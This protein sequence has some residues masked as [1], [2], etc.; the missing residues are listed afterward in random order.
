MVAVALPTFIDA[1][2][3]TL[4]GDRLFRMW[5][6]FLAYSVIASGQGSA[7]CWQILAHP[8][9]YDYNF[10][11]WVDKNESKKSMNV[12]LVLL[13]ALHLPTIVLCWGPFTHQYFASQ[14]EAH[15]TSSPFRTGGRRT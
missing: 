15:G 10:D 8:N 4:T 9:V 11:R 5:E 3:E 7:T 2:R 6:F 14:D 12:F 1:E 13:V